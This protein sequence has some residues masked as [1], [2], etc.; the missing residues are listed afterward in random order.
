[1]ISLDLE[2]S[3]LDSGRCGIWQ[4]GALELENPTNYFLQ[5]GRIDDEDEVVEGALKVTGKTEEELR[6]KKKQSQKQLIVNYLDW[7]NTIKEKLF[8]GQNVG[9]DISFIQNKCIRYGIMN[10]FREVQSQRSFDL[11]TLAQ[12]RYKQIEDKYLLDEKGKSKMN[13]SAIIGICGIPDERIK[14]TGTEVVKQGKPHNALEDCKL[15][16]ECFYRLIEGKNLFPEYSKYKIP[17]ELIK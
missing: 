11:H 14:V 1:M 12:E 9:W 17:K 7:L 16:G 10:K 3:G 2:T 4:I 13:F 15:I 8:I 5:E 6:D